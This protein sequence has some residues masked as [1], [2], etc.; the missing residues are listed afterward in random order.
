VIGRPRR[1][2]EVLR[3]LLRWEFQWQIVFLGLR[4]GFPGWDTS[5]QHPKTA[6]LKWYRE[7]ANFR[8]KDEERFWQKHYR[9]NV[10]K[11]D[12][13]FTEKIIE[14]EPRDVPPEP[15]I[16]AALCKPATSAKEIRKLCLRSLYLK[17]RPGDPCPTALYDHAEKFCKAKRDDRY[18]GGGKQNRKSSEGKRVD[19]LARVLAG[20]SMPKPMRP[21]TAED[22]L[23]KM[24]HAKRCICWRCKF[25][26]IA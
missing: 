5:L 20:L 18:P 1:D 6:G 12:R 3:E 11:A 2:P 23:R 17:P 14:A 13:E 9:N 21:A 7:P 24:R 22:L 25:S 26:T 19:Y 15:E 4:E 16:W 10:K 8:T